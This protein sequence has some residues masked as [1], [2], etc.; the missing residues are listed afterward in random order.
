V[1]RPP[2]PESSDPRDIAIFVDS[3]FD[4]FKEDLLQHIDQKFEEQRC[5]LLS[6]YPANDPVKHFMWHQR[7]DEQEAGQRDIRQGVRRW[8]VV[9]L[10]SVLATWNWGA[11]KDALKA[12]WK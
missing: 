4:A 9:G 12:L 5:F 10:L 1:S 11:I 7:R 3:R 2:H 8:G 6:A